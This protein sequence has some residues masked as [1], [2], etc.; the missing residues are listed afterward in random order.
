MI[1]GVVVLNLLVR[2]WSNIEAPVKPEEVR[3]LFIDVIY[4]DRL[5]N[6]TVAEDSNTA[7]NPTIVRSRLVNIDWDILAMTGDPPESEIVGGDVLL[8]NLFEDSSFT[9]NLDHWE[10]RSENNFTWIG[11]IEGDKGS[12]VTIVV[13]DDVMVSNIRV[14]GESYQVRYMGE[15]AH[16]IREID[17]RFFPPEGEPISVDN[18]SQAIEPFLS[19]ADGEGAQ[20]ANDGSTLDVM[21][22]FTPAARAAAGGTAAMN[23]L[24]NLAVAERFDPF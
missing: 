4:S 18:P 12:Q 8:L 23:A 6:S 2:G 17:E 24:I 7:I 9:A 11:H 22:V 15:D 1:L 19:T 20:A 21:V 3:D 14:S 10:A 13:Q 16:V 5:A